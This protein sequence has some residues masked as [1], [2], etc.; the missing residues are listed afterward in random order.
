M[1]DPFL[2]SNQVVISF[3]YHIS[4]SID[5]N[6]LVSHF[7]SVVRK[8]EKFIG[9][10]KLK[11]AIFFSGHR[12]RGRADGGFQCGRRRARSRPSTEHR[13]N[14]GRLSATPPASRHVQSAYPVES[15]KYTW[16][17]PQYS[18]RGVLTAFPQ[19]MSV[20]RYRAGVI[21]SDTKRTEKASKIHST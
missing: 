2:I 16:V 15:C 13:F 1:R 6:M 18:R 10:R 8:E 11:I 4:L 21:L 7:C 14:S 12:A 17:L 19:T 20:N 3:G 9:R 5:N